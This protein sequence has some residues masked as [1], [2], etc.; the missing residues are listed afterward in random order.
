MSACGY[1]RPAGSAVFFSSQLFFRLIHR[2]VCERTSFSQAKERPERAQP[3]HS[4]LF[5]LLPPVS[6]GV[7]LSFHRRM[8]LFF[9]RRERATISITSEGEN[10]DNSREQNDFR[11]NNTISPRYEKKTFCRWRNLERNF[12]EKQK[13]TKRTSYLY[14]GHGVA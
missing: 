4:F 7:Y 5:L 12:P 13:N 3:T 9:L 6:P 14:H 11:L 1:K 10:F 8:F 2:Q